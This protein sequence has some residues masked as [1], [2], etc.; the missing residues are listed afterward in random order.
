MGPMDAEDDDTVNK[1]ATKTVCILCGS[2]DCD[3]GDKCNTKRRRY[4]DTASPTKVDVSRISGGAL[5]P[6]TVSQNYYQP[7]ADLEI[8][9]D[10]GNINNRN[11]NTRT[12]EN[13]SLAN[14]TFCPPIIMYNVNVK[15]LVEQLEAR[16]PKINF[17]IKNINRHK[18][19][20]FI[21]D[22]I[23]YTEMMSLLREKKINS[24]SFTPK[25]LRQLSFVVRGL[26]Y[27]TEIE[28]IKAVLDNVIPNVVDKVSKF[29]TNYSKKNSTD[30]GLFL[31][32]L[33]Q[34]KGLKDITHI[35]YILNQVIVW[36]KPKRN[37][38][39]I[40]CRRCQL[41]GHMA[42]NCN[43]EFK[44]VKCD[45][46]HEPGKCDKDIDAKVDPVCVNCGKSGHPANWRGC[47]AY[48]K[49][50]SDKKYKLNEARERKSTAANNVAKLIATPTT[51][52]GVSYSSHFHNLSNSPAA[53][54][55][56]NSKPSIITE[57]LKLSKY[58]MEPEQLTLEQEIENFL[59]EYTKMPRDAAKLKFKTLLTKVKN[60]YD[61]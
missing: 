61:P 47:S 52:P 55:R 38:R 40:Q 22:I 26:H 3:N 1:Q 58:F 37:E 27:K 29:I 35:K 17:K 33:Q 53:P 24:Y 50:I 41:W 15:L 32:T 5:P 44:C 18:S 20:L 49:Y 48:Q 9:S 6:I 54:T 12:K 42:K 21:S 10:S 59:K 56:Q 14:K 51:T 4:D 57:F 8:V 7:L 2:S 45:G 19:K 11:N 36:E 31:V 28:D 43:R 16:T 25:E 13:G 39:E 23:V 46:Q 30:T 34:G 60:S